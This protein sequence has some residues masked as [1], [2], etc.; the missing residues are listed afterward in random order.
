[1]RKIIL[2]VVAVFTIAFTANA[3]DDKFEV[4]ISGGIPTGDASDFFSFSIGADV[5]YLWNVSDKFYAG[6]STGMTNADGD[7]VMVG[8][9]SISTDD[10]QFVPLAAGAR[11]NV[12]GKFFVGADVGYAIGINEGNDG[13]FYYRPKIGY[14]ITDKINVNIMYTGIALDDADFTTIGLGVLFGL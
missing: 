13:G 5:S 1:M 12:A 11:Y 2:A 14:D 8:N 3:Q 7:E 9:A 6:F 10:A 4:G